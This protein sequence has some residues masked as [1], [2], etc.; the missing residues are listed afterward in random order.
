MYRGHG[1][2]WITTD[3][4]TE[5]LKKTDR[6]MKALSRKVLLFLDNA[7]AL[8][9]LSDSL[10]LSITQT[11]ML[12]YRK[13]QFQYVL[14]QMDSTDKTGFDILRQISVLDTIY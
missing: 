3:I 10:Q 4:M 12:K 11:L 2:V 9:S 8:P 1:K 14:G 13:R 5:R 7:L 6:Q